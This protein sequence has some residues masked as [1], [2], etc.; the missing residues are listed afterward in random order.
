MN[1][2]IKSEI[3]KILAYDFSKS[4]YS[5]G[6]LLKII[7]FMKEF[8][9]SN[10]FYMSEVIKDN[11]AL[12]QTIIKLKNDISELEKKM[13]RDYVL[14]QPPVKKSRIKSIFKKLWT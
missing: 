10:E 6:E 5:Y 1:N 7:H 8:I 9:Y 13:H 14:K 4:T 12:G 2:E 11:S 3:N